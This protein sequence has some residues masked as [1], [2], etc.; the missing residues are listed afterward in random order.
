M[1]MAHGHSFDDTPVLSEAE[2]TSRM[3]AVERLVSRYFG[4]FALAATVLAL[5]V[6]LR[7]IL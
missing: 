5:G 3:V 7:T 6:G 2:L 4:Y 1:T